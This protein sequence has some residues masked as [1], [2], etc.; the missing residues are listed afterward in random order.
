MRLTV[1]RLAPLSDDALAPEQIETL[2]ALAE[3]WRGLNLFRTSVRSPGGL[4]SLIPA[5]DYIR[6][7]SILAAR[8]REIVVLRI[9]WLCGSGYEWTQH[10]FIGRQAGLTKDE[11]V[12]VK[13]G[14]DAGSW[15]P[16][17]RALIRACDELHADQFITAA[18]WAALGQ[19]FDEAEIMDVVFIAG[20]YVTV[21][22]IANAFGVQLD[23]GQRLDPDLYRPEG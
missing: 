10:V 12:A 2:A 17:D 7:S 6:S 20:H 15:S 11:V 22:M 16:A 21:S 23:E 18:T 3:P 9:G 8:E 1:P 5:G 13:A 14:A 4:A 19:H